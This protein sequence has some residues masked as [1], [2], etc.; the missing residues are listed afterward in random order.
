M[1]SYSVKPADDQVFPRRL[2]C[3][4]PCYNLC[5]IG[6]ILSRFLALLLALLGALCLAPS[7]SV[8]AAD[9][10]EQP[11]RIIAVGDLH[12]DFEAWSA[13]AEASGI[14]NDEGKWSGGQAVLVQMGDVTDRGPDSL[15]IIL[16]LQK[17]AEQASKVGG[18]VII[19]LGNHEAMNVTG[20]LRYVHHGEYDAFRDR[21]SER[22]RDA[23][24]RANH[25][26][27]EEAYA[28]LVP[29]L[30]PE[31]AKAR[32][33]ADTPLGKLEHRRAWRPGGALGQWASGLP[34]IAKVGHILFVHGGLSAERSLEPLDDINTR[35]SSALASGDPEY[36]AILEDPLGP[37]WYRGN[38]VRGEPADR[39]RISVS[40]ELQQVLAF[41]D[42]DLLV[43]GHTP[44]LSGIAVSDDGRLVQTDTGISAYYGGPLSYLEIRGEQLTAHERT[45][46]G[47][48]SSRALNRGDGAKEEKQ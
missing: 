37:L 12:G 48:W 8:A 18:R 43:V 17:L 41:H 15:K 31:E 10:Y 28:V 40:E 29:P 44:S 23:T 20:D 33:Y 38:L 3:A 30:G 4:L 25:E 27:I 26:L 46:D 9:D 1:S 7:A 13:I 45:A 2:Y 24:W 47:V 39:P 42:A 35:I 16:H 32:W 6:G 5:P 14:A 21:R 11:E 22:R 34:A 19:L 36:I